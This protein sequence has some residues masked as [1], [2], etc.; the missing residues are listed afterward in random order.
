[1]RCIDSY[2]T[3]DARPLHKAANDI[4]CNNAAC[5]TSKKV[6]RPSRPDNPYTKCQTLHVIYILQINSD[7]FTNCTLLTPHITTYKG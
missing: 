1:M 5:N 4:Q 7:S 2:E 3:S 6:S